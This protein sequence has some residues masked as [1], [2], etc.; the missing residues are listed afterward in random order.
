MAYYDRDYYREDGDGGNH[1]LGGVTAV[2]VLLAIN[3][4][5]WVL[6][7]ILTNSARADNFS[8]LMWL[9]FNMND[10]VHHWQVWRWFTY[11]FVHSVTNFFSILFNMMVLVS[12]GPMLENW[13]GSKKFTAFYLICGTSGAV[14]F[15]LLSL[16]PG[17]INGGGLIGASGSIYGILVAC[18][19]VFPTQQMRVLF[20][21]YEFKL[22]TMAT[23]LLGI[24]AAQVLVGSTGAANGAAH[25]GGALVG[26]FLVHF[27][28]TLDWTRHLSLGRYS[29]G[30][31]MARH[32]KNVRHKKVLADQAFEAQIDHILEKV[33]RE[34]LQSL[35]HKEKRMLQE[36]TERQRQS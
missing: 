22:R 23:I 14:I 9:N 20:L 4:L 25:L 6:D 5:I 18:A 12:L 8:P 29:P 17:F 24:A 19:V 2:K 36:A 34:G 31:V 13:W 15:S 16:I 10:A 35:T 32:R 28:S 3:V 7:E 26:F 11:Q 21:P 30:S 1:I 33:A 27:S